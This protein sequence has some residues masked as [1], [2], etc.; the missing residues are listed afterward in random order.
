MNTPVLDLRRVDVHILL[1]DLCQLVREL[2]RLSLTAL[3]FQSLWFLV[4]GRCSWLFFNNLFFNDLGRNDDH[5]CI[6][7]L[8][9]LLFLGVI[10]SSWRWQCF[11]VIQLWFFCGTLLSWCGFAF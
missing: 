5:D 4:G 1:K 6:W 2:T 10:C 7:L 3:R 9:L 8:L 11:F